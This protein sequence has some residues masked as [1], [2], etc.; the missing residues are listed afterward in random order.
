M[1]LTIVVG[2]TIAVVAGL[3]VFPGE[4]AFLINYVG[5]TLYTLT[6]SEE[7][8]LQQLEPET[9]TTIRA[10]I[11][12]LAND[13]LTIHVGQTLRSTAEERAAIDSGLSAIKSHSWHEIG[14]AAD[15][16]PI[17]PDTGQADT[18]G[19]RDDLFIQMQQAAV[20]LGLRQIAY[21]DDWSR[22][23]ITNAQGKKIW[24]GGHMENHGPY[25]TIAEAIA[26][27]GATYGIG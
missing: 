27:E 13:G 5:D 9:Q 22:R 11:Q 17:N 3:L 10:L 8:R 20:A 26:A 23:Y 1:L 2:V 12:N 14:R 7:T 19:V 16:Y 24:D 6:T 25:A 15:L 21:N 18:Q 4:T